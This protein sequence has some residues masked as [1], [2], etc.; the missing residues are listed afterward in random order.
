VIRLYKRMGNTLKLKVS[1]KDCKIISL[2]DE[3]GFV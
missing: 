1:S 2:F 3:T